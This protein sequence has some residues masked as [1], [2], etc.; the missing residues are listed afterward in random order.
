MWMDILFGYICPSLGCLMSSAMYAAPVNELR[1]ALKAG[2]LGALNSTPWAVMTGNAVGWCAY[3]YYAWDPFILASNIPGL[4][5]SIWL[6][7]GAA[8]LQYLQVRRE[9]DESTQR[10]TQTGQ[11]IQNESG[12]F[13]SQETILLRILIVWL[14]LLVCIG[15]LGV[16]DGYEKVVVGVLANINVIFFYGA[17]LQTMQT[18]IT[19]K[20]SE[21]IHVPTMIMNLLNTSFWIL[22]GVAEVDPVIYF[23]N[24]VGFGLGIIQLLLRLMYPVRKTRLAPLLQDIEGDGGATNA[25]PLVTDDFPGEL[26]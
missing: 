9:H 25:S 19:E 21:S 14:S 20:S 16:A 18:V 22:Y 2:K 3:S 24:I 15:W 5:V 1:C 17:P 10:Q 23:P 12:I 4:V 26:L 6:N 7:M 8:K 13:V 11:P